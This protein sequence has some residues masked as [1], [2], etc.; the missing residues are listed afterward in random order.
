MRQYISLQQISL[1]S[2][3]GT[4]I[5]HRVW[6]NETPILTFLLSFLQLFLFQCLLA[7]IW[8]TFVYPRYLTPFRDIPCGHVSVLYFSLS[9]NLQSLT[10]NQRP[11][12]WRRF[13]AEPNNELLLS[14]ADGIPN[15]GL[16]R[17]L[18]FMNAERFLV[19]SSAGVTEIMV[20][21]PYDFVKS[22]MARRILQIMLGTGLIVAEGEQHKHQKKGLLPAFKFRHIKELYPIF[23]SKTREYVAALENEVLSSST[24]AATDIEN[25][26]QRVTLDIIGVAGFGKDFN[27]LKQ[28]DDALNRSYNKAFNIATAAAG[29]FRLMAVIFPVWV[30]RRLPIE[31][32]EEIQDGIS[33]VRD[34]CRGLIVAKKDAIANGKDLGQDI[35]SVAMQ[36]GLF[37][38]TEL[39]DQCLTFLGAG[40]ETTATA[41]GFAAY[42][43][44]QPQNRHMQERLRAEIRAKLPSP[45]SDEMVTSEMVDSVIYLNAVCTEVV[46]L[47]SPIST[48]RRRSVK[49]T[50]VLGRHIPVDT[51]FTITPYAFNLSSDMWSS[52]PHEFNPDRWIENNGEKIGKG[53]AV[54]NC[55]YMS[56]GAGPRICIGQSF[57]KGSFSALLAGLV[58]KF[59]IR[60]ATP[61]EGGPNDDYEILHGIVT[62]I[63]GGVKVKLTPLDGW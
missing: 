52:N 53:G 2:A 46:R 28:P 1:L 41:L 57:A 30:L 24:N 63:V 11:G 48:L 36:S 34:F 29:Q 12:N 23:W 59:D 49:N 20:S 16:I 32:V 7:I 15:D 6:S 25:W 26:N 54:N 38:E 5:R 62:K 19:T 43:L 4:I 45:S 55:S 9:Q 58:G 50:T 8:T 47:H 44:S 17:Y 31:R 3:V 10:Y 35:L 27:A 33:A 18:G 56:F 40:H 21:K 39:I 37:N 22:P 61:E 60:L 13:F 51:D 14:F 42:L